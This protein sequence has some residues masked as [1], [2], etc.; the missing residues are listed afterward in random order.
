MARSLLLASLFCFL[1]GCGGGL[2]GGG[3]T[4]ANAQALN[5][6]L[7]ASWLLQEYPQGRIRERWPNGQPRRISYRVTDPA[8]KGQTLLLEFNRQGIATGK[9]YSGRMLRPPPGRK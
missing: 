8:G 9:K 7:S 3:L 5:P 4:L 1:I 2:G 6:G